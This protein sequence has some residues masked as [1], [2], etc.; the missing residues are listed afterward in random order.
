MLIFRLAFRNIVGAG[1]RTWLNVFVLSAA[2]VMIVWVQGMIE[3]M[4]RTIMTFKIDTDLG[5]GQYWSRSYDPYDPL[6]YEDSHT[7]LSDELAGLISTGDA[8]PM[9][10]TTG[11]IYP[12][13]RIRSAII[14]GM[15]PDQRVLDLP[16]HELSPTGDGAVPAMIG[17]EM[18]RETELGVGDYVT[19][20][21]RDANGT[22]DADEVRIAQIVDFAVPGMDRGQIWLPLGELQRMLVVPG[23]ASLIVV[24]KGYEAGP[25]DGAA[26]TWH[27]LDFLLKDVVEM[28]KFKSGGSY[29]LYA[30]MLFMALLAIFD[31][32]V[33]AI[34]RRRKEIGTLMALGMDRTRVIALFTVEGAMHGVLALGVGAVYGIPLLALTLAKGIPVP[35]IMS[36]MGIPVPHV[37]Y[38]S[39][40]LRLVVVTTLLV[41]VSVTVVSMLPASNIAKL[42]PTDALKGKAT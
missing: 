16:S 41:L 24:E 35:Q 42:K 29:I 4:N 40:G 15:D 17:S 31:T 39:Y 18:A 33:L 36:D 34:W 3:G 7:L 9:L 23:E 26:W 20:R 2:F 25:V 32:Q 10:I 38:P 6:T 28:I 11:A 27:D 12:Q 1:L 19:V 8:T 13:G 21:W 22:F 37:L 14:V 5:G 30:L